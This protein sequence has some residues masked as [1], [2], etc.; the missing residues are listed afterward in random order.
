MHSY[1]IKSQPTTAENPRLN[2]V[3]RMCGT[4]GDMIRTE[5]F[6]DVKNPMREVDVLLS[7]CAWALRSTASVVIGKTPGQMA[8]NH[9]I[10]MYVAIEMNWDDALRKKQAQIMKN[11][12][13][14]NKKRSNHAC[15]VGPA[16]QHCW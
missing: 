16:L 5:D 3:E 15:K 13:I 12:T 4:L 9:N 7:S 14:E 11:S 1:G 8:F 10:I 2:L 6:A